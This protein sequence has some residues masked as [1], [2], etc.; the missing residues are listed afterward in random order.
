LIQEGPQ[1][2]WKKSLNGVNDEERKSLRRNLLTEN[3]PQCLKWGAFSQ[4]R[5]ITN[6]VN[7]VDAAREKVDPPFK[8]R[9]EAISVR[10]AQ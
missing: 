2:W 8:H 5:R 1:C 3:C 9:Q 7:V 4:G 6:S 10:Y